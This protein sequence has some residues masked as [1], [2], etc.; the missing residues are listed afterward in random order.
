MRTQPTRPQPT[1]ER[2]MPSVEVPIPAPAGQLLQVRRLTVAYPAPH[3]DVVRVVEGFDLDIGAGERVAVVGESGAGKSVL[4]RAILRLDQR[5]RIEGRVLFGGSDLVTLPERELRAVRGTG[6]SMVFQD[7]FGSLNPRLKV[8]D[9]VSEV[10]RIRG[11]SRKEAGARAIA[12]L[13]ELGVHRAAERVSAYPHEFSGGMRQ[14]VML[15]IA[16]I[17]NPA[18][19]IADE[20][21]TALDARVQQQVLD[22]LHQISRD[23]GLAVLLITHDLGVVSGFADRVAVMYAGRKVE[24]SALPQLFDAP[25]HPYT[26][27]LLGA[28]PRIGAR[29]AR[30]QAIPGIQPGPAERPSGCRFHPRCP[31]AQAVCRETE[32]ELR[33][34]RSGASVSCHFPGVPE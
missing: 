28:M 8:G 27:G 20:A 16:L 30:L 4:A 11:V 34:W 12:V 25:L 19:L 18:L 22:L 10:L 29:V 17:G 7:P 33:T 23:R 14:R 9:Q 2:A 15:A 3:G 21:T 32:P 5:A 24:E 6:I 13:E 31:L 1:D 26:R